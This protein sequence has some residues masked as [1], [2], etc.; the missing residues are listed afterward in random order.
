[1]HSK[2]I[3]VI[4]GVQTMF[5]KHI[6]TILLNEFK[7]FKEYNKKS[8]FINSKLSLQAGTSVEFRMTFVVNCI[9][10]ET[11]LADFFNIFSRIF[12]F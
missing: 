4:I 6:T 10:R 12:D 11:E 8:I 7:D 5:C 9:G 2:G 3:I 1:M